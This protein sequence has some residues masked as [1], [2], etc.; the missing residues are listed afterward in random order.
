MADQASQGELGRPR[1]RLPKL[2]DSRGVC[3]ALCSSLARG[4]R[5]S[6]RISMKNRPEMVPKSSQNRPKIDQKSV[7]APPPDPLGRQRGSRERSR[8][9]PGGL[10]G[11]P[12]GGVGAPG[13]ALGSPGD[14]SG[15]PRDPL[16]DHVEAPRR[17]KRASRARFATRLALQARS[18]RFSDDFRAI[19]DRFLVR[20]ASYST[21]RVELRSTRFERGRP[22]RNHVNSDVS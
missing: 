4:A 3:H 9:V 16:G 1:S 2:P 6:S 5:K 21:L 13:D 19:S 15:A 12:G 18:E 11:A 10:G 7:P 14:P 8:A 17:E 20:F 22:S